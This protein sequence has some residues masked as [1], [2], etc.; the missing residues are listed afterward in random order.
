VLAQPGVR[1]IAGA[2]TPTHLDALAEGLS[3]G[4]TPDQATDVASDF[5]GS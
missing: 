1:P 3:L 2:R 4:L 5:A